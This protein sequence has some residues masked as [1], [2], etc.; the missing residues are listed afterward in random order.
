MGHM[1]FI[2]NQGKKGVFVPNIAL[3][4]SGFAFNE[5]AELR[6]MDDVL[7]VL[8]AAM[9][10]SELARAAQ[11]LHALASELNM[12]LA[13]TCGF[14]GGDGC[15]PDD[16]GRA[17]LKELPEETVEMMSDTGVCLPR[18]AELVEE[19]EIVYG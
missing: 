4:Q 15:S 12:R 2:L 10:A 13:M 1:K 17:V 6:P 18:L 5:Q 9:T 8:Q 7:V 16:R 14:C 3:K 11:R 19:G